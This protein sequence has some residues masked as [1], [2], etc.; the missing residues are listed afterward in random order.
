MEIH[1]IQCT[2]ENSEAGV[3]VVIAGGIVFS[4]DDIFLRFGGKFR[5]RAHRCNRMCEIS[6]PELIRCGTTL[7]LHTDIK[8][9]HFKPLPLD[10]DYYERFRRAV[11]GGHRKGPGIIR[12]RTGLLQEIPGGITQ[13]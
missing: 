4:Q 12:D 3:N 8:V 2:C 1:D 13:K 11:I 7:H 5:C 10:I 9:S 6:P